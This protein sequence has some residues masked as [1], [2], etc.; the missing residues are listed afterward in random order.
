MFL[1]YRDYSETDNLEKPNFGKKHDDYTFKPK[2][3]VSTL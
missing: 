1:R 3:S 2:E